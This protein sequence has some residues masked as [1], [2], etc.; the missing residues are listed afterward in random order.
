MF[1]FLWG[2]QVHVRQYA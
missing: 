1:E 2:L